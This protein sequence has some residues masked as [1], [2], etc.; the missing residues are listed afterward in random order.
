MLIII[1]DTRET[2]PLE[3][4]PEIRT[5]R[6]KLDEGDY[7]LVG[8]EDRISI[9]RKTLSDLCGSL[10]KGRERFERELLRL[11]RYEFAAIIIES[12]WKTIIRG[13]FP[14]SRMKPAP[15]IGSLMSFVLKHGIFPITAENHEIAGILTEKLLLKFEEY[16]RKG[17]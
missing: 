3:F 16:A 12:N 1:I 15:I 10:G 2:W 11:A 9:E 5:V 7:S 17:Q 6:K 13:S 14:F 4:S 8:Y